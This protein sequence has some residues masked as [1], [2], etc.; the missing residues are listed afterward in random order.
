[1]F[2]MRHLKLFCFVNENNGNDESLYNVTCLNYS[3][4]LVSP[5][6]FFEVFFFKNYESLSFDFTFHQLDTNLTVFVYTF[7]IYSLEYIK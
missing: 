7:C 4:F 6:I 1:M 2:A 3:P 5:I